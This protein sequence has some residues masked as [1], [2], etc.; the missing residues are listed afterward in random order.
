[1]RIRNKQ[2]THYEH[3]IEKH[4]PR[5]S[6]VILPKRCKCC[7]NTIVLEKAWKYDW[8]R[9]LSMDEGSCVET[10]ILCKECCSSVDKTLAIKFE[11]DVSE[12]ER[13]KSRIYNPYTMR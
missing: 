8:Y 12:I 3:L 7:G 4:N 11:V 13:S 10:D 6:I 5:F 2:I 1:M 9:H